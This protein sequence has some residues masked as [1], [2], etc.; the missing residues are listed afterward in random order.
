MVN[1]QTSLAVVRTDISDVDDSIKLEN[2]TDRGGISV[3]K[4]SMAWVHDYKKK[5]FIVIFIINIV[6]T[7]KKL[8]NINKR[9]I[10]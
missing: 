9:L 7:W 2:A 1:R 10:F 8:T 3:Q 5:V 4:A 6:R